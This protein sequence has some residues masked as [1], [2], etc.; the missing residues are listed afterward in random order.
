MGKK[1]F[2]EILGDLVVKPEGKPTLVPVTDKRPELQVS[3][4]AD[5]FTN[6]DK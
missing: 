4:A 3:T 6:I 5:D 1:Q 2:S